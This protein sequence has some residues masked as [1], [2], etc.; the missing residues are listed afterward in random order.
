[1]FPK[2]ALFI[3]NTDSH[4]TRKKNIIQFKEAKALF[5]GL[6]TA[7]PIAYGGSQARARIGAAAA[8]LHHSHSNSWI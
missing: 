2:H 5:F 3:H 7:T 1:M 6:F 8:G 4:N